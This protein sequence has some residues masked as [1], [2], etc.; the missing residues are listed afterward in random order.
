[1]KSEDRNAFYLS[2]MKEHYENLCLE[3]CKFLSY[4][5]KIRESKI[6]TEEEINE[7]E[8]LELKF[9]KKIEHINKLLDTNMDI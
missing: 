5:L 2:K 1:M 6:S 8:N 7:L 3:Y 4:S 9:K